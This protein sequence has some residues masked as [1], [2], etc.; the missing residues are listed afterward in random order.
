M[1]QNGKTQKHLDIIL[2]HIGDD[3]YFLR[4]KL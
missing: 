4:N 2:E 1:S 3:L